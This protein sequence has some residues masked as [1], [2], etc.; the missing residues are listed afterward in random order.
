MAEE[1]TSPT[2]EEARKTPLNEFVAHQRK[3]AEEACA[4]LNALIPPE[5]RTHSRTARE[6]FLKGFKVLADGMAEMVDRE[7]NRVRTNPSG[8]G[9][10]TTGKSK[11]KIE[12]S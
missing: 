9:P 10:S 1:R 6:E 5:F 8:G 12:V 7:L 2:G 3:A 4:A 11:V